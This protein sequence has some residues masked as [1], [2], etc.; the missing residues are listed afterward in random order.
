MDAQAAIIASRLDRVADLRREVKRLREENLRL[1][2]ENATLL[3][4]FD[5]AV[6]AAADL[7]ALPSAQA[8][9]LIVDGWNMI[10]GEGEAVAGMAPRGR[11]KSPSALIAHFRDYIA[12]NPD[13][14]VWIV[15]DGERENVYGENRIRVSYTGGRG[16]QRADRFICDFMRMARFKGLASRIKLV[17][18][19]K[20]LLKEAARLVD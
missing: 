14:F 17:T 6:L 9:F 11:I 18:A 8:R 19:D 7:A 10:L 12:A 2:D 13:D 3:A 16:S 20:K 5:L 15:F 1:A 4:H